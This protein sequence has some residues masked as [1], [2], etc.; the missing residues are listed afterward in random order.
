MKT[1]IKTVQNELFEIDIEQEDSVKR[2][3]EKI[4]ELK[5]ETM[6]VEGM[7][8]I[9]A[10]KILVDDK[11]LLTEY[12]VKESDF[13]VV[14]CTKKPVAVDPNLQRMMDMGFSKDQAENAL[15]ASGNN[16]DIAADLLMGG[17]DD[18]PAPPPAATST[19]APAAEQGPTTGAFPQMAQAG[20]AAQNPEMIQ[21]LLQR[22]AASNPEML[23]R[24]QQN[25]QEFMQVLNNLQGLPEAERMQMLNALHDGN[26]GGGDEEEMAIPEIF[27]GELPAMSPEEQEAISRLMELGF[28]QAQAIEAYMVCDKNEN[29]AANYL[30]NSM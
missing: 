2:V 13:L 20:G 5:S 28:S 15:Q 1:K 8:L 16:P 23:E 11:M 14:M 3:K 7:K 22:V 27:Q 4:A 25:P 18:A 12:N 24:I 21:A 29:V 10:G 6:T 17:G 19:P 9:F 26:M 30:F